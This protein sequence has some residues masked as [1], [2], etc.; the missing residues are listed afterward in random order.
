[1]LLLKSFKKIQIGRWCLPAREG[2]RFPP[3]SP[4]L[5]ILVCH[6][7]TRIHV[8]LLGPCFK[9]GR[10]EAFC[11]HLERPSVPKDP[12]GRLLPRSSPR[13]AIPV[14]NSGREPHLPSWAPFPAV[15]TDAD[16]PGDKVHHPCGGYQQHQGFDPSDAHR[17]TSPCG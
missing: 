7:N 14:Y 15:R 2:Q 3:H 10:L 16:P 6:Q 12:R 9:T 4:S 13:Q 5:R 1:M 17:L 11:Q 8:R